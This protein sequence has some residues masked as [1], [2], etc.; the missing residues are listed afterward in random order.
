MNK[1]FFYI[2]QYGFFSNTL[3]KRI[4]FIYTYITRKQ[5]NVGCV[6]CDYP[7]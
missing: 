3:L 5:T 2:R 7:I 4:Y 1:T 6:K